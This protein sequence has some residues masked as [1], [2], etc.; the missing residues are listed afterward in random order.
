M[1]Q[2][3]NLSAKIVKHQTQ[4]EASINRVIASGWLV[5]GPEVKR[6]EQSFAAYLDASH[7]ISLANGT[8]AIELALKAMGIGPGD[9]VATVANPAYTPLQR[10]W[11]LVQSLISWMSIAIP[12]VPPLQK[13]YA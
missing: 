1:Q 5:L 7:C 11:R 4:I 3:N 8:D 9:R 12:V 13:S 2:I 6:F 10:C